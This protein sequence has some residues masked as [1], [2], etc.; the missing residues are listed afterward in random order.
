MPERATL[1]QGVQLGVESTP[2]T[3]VAANKKLQSTSIETKVMAEIN[4][5]RPMGTKYATTEIL[6]KEWSEFEI[7]GQGSYQDTSY[8]LASCLA[9]AAPVE[10]ATSGAYTWTFAPSSTAEDTVKTYTVEHGSAVRAHKLTNALITEIEY[11][12]TRDGVEVSGSGIGQRVEDGITL[13]ATPDTVAEKPMLPTDVDVYIDS[14][15][16]GLGGTKLTRAMNVN[17]K[18]SD[19]FGPVWVLNSANSSF[20]STI[21]TEPSAEITVMVEADT[22]GMGLLT[23]MRSTATKFLR[24]SATSADNAGNSGT[25]KYKFEWDAAVKVKEVGDF[26][27]EDGI[28]AIEWTFDMVHDPTWG[29]AYTVS[30]VNSLTDL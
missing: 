28:Y 11:D 29:K 5:F 6:G 21:E 20:V 24:V 13:T 4:S 8:L 7:E 1:T 10:I 25:N 12:F 16:A 14:T 18:V 19:R 23:D 30:C 2:G 15:S 9:Y 26:S 27:D 17:V 22:Q 3:S